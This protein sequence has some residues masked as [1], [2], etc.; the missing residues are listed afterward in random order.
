LNNLFIETRDPLFG[1]IVFFALIFVITFFS[2]WWGRYKAKDDH[3]YLD[4]FINGFNS[5]SHEIE[6]KELI[7]SGNIST[8]A[9]LILAST[10]MKQGDY[11]K[12]IGVYGSIIEAEKDPLQ[13]KKTL[14]LL[15]KAYIKAG[16]LE[17]AKEV[18][19][20]IL[21]NEPRTPEAL[22]ALL[23]VYD[24]LKDYK[25][26][27]EVL[28][29]LHELN[30]DIQSE[31]LYL[32]CAY[33][34]QQKSLSEEKKLEALLLVYKQ[35]ASFAYLIFEYLFKTNSNAAWQH[36]RSSD[37]AR[38]SDILWY[39]P[40][41]KL[42]M[43]I[44]ASHHYLREFFTAK[45]V[46]DLA[47]SSTIFELDILIKLHHANHSGATLQFE[48]LCKRCKHLF[49]FSFHRCPNCHSINTVIPE[50]ILTKDIFE[51]NYTF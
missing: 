44:I 11:E 43:E 32:E 31:K 42:S 36:L 26:A 2:Y 22:H 45:R 46:C 24:Q 1:I 47:N 50:M 17:R 20:K 10:H 35:D 16:F 21:K 34:M 41:E 4:D 27:L 39:L 38:L 13:R 18:F 7:C 49:P 19:L 48:Y 8:S 3:R 9:A 6:V 12:S 25:K 33:L 28:E 51:E 14:I 23:L 37:Y 29:P 30:Q 5:K 15:G 40:K